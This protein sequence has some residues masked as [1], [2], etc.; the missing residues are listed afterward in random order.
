MVTNGRL[1]NVYYECR[2]NS[3]ITDYP[4]VKISTSFGD[5]YVR[6]TELRFALQEN[7]WNFLTFEDYHAPQT[8]RLIS[9]Q[10]YRATHGGP[11][12][13]MSS[14]HC[15]PGTERKLL[16]ILTY[17]ININQTTQTEQR[18][19]IPLRGS[20]TLSMY[21]DKQFDEG[22]DIERIL[23]ASGIVPAI[24]NYLAQFGE[25]MRPVIID[26]DE[27]G[28]AFIIIRFTDS[29]NMI[30]LWRQ[31]HQ[32]PQV[33]AGYHVILRRSKEA[34][35]VEEG[36]FQTPQQRQERQRYQSQQLR[37]QQENERT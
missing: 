35:P 36:D 18:R 28:Q 9:T 15:Q 12:S 1:Y 26:V 16:S 27:N 17:Q 5:C 11:G 31:F 8:G 32:S 3:I 33:F 34:Y 20:D 30:K 29:S 14:L 4:I 37:Q 19:E 10:A 22:A 2:G 24:D 25:L 6:E 13:Y 7:S 21:I 23:L